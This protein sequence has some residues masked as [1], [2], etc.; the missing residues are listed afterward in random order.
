MS[1]STALRLVAA[2][3]IIIGTC[4]AYG[5]GAASW[6]DY[7]SMVRARR[8]VPAQ[9]LL[10]PYRSSR[11]QESRTAIPLSRA[12]HGAAIAEKFGVT[13]VEQ[14]IIERVGF[15]VTERVSYF[16]FGSAYMGIYVH[17]LPV[18]VTSDSILH[19]LHMSYDAIL[20]EAEYGL[21]VPA[22]QDGMA[23]MRAGFAAAVDRYADEPRMA[24]MLG[25]L[26]LYIAVTRA[27]LGEEPT[28]HFDGTHTTLASVRAAVEAQGAIE[29]P[30]FCAEPR[31]VDFSQFTVRGHY[32]RSDV[33]GRYFQAM[34]WLGREGFYLDGGDGDDAPP[35]EDVRRQAI[36]ACLLSDL[37][38]E[39]GTRDAID[40][41]EGV[42]DLMVGARRTD[43][44]AM[45]RAVRREAGVADPRELLDDDVWAAFSKATW[46]ATEGQYRIL[47]QI[48]TA[49]D[50]NEAETRG[51]TTF[52][53]L[54][55]REV[56]D[57][58]VLGSVVFDRIAHAGRKVQRMRPAMADVLFVL[59][60]DDALA[61]LDDELAKYRYAPNLTAARAIVD[62]YDDDAWSS[63]FYGGWLGAIRGLNPTRERS[64]RPSFMR[65][66]EW[67]GKTMNTQLASWSQLKHDSLLYTQ[68]AYS[69]GSIACEYPTSYVEPVPR[70]YAALIELARAMTRGIDGLAPEGSRLRPRLLGY[71]QHLEDTSATLAEVIR[72]QSRG[73]PRSDAEKDFLKKM[74]FTVSSGCTIAYT[75]WYSKLFY[76]GEGGLRK[77]DRVVA[78]VFTQPTDDEGNVVGRVIHVGAGSIDTAFVVCDWGDGESCAYVGPVMSY[79]EHS[80][81]KFK[82]LTDDEWKDLYVT[83]AAARPAFTSSY[84]AGLQ[85]GHRGWG[86]RRPKE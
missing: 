48:T 49:A 4:Q 30:L 39:P 37:A 14:D 76:T 28:P 82:R 32:T 47:T 12:H 52:K 44:F 13:P 41:V 40:R 38:M 86:L 19:A 81:E 5:S 43:P 24:P 18:F 68:Q 6:D 27:L 22:L 77:D 72:K 64:A 2:L 3:G 36:S 55:Q 1:R 20:M 34:M 78:D 70:M 60:N 33:L 16:S 63:S 11:V 75:G 21:L 69:A 56:L 73:E 46:D 61:T 62:A 29:A 23:A 85:D 74:L 58:N 54:G 35:D 53:M 7:M 80:S 66:D 15:A 50:E 67:A 84:L 51:P 17:D 83:P 45:L 9:D 25:D 79:Y 59:G 42:L 65:T 26:D 8:E 57:A 31:T 10:A 71:F